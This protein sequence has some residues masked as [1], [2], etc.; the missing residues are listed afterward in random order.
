MTRSTRGLSA[1]AELLVEYQQLTPALCDNNDTVCE[2]K[3]SRLPV[4]NV[5]VRDMF[6]VDR[7]PFSPNSV[8]QVSSESLSG[9]VT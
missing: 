6:S 3:S 4:C 9:F 2:E 8:R 5:A 7:D 1:R